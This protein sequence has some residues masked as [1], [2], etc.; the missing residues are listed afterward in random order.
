M[1]WPVFLVYLLACFGAGATGGLFPPGGWYRALDKPGF[2]PPDWVFPLT[3]TYL[4]V[5]AA[6]AASRVAG[7]RAR[8]SPSRSGRRRSRSTRSGPRC[9]SA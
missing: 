4:Y 5:A 6:W 3:W 1:D 8:S 2:T 9:S 7:C